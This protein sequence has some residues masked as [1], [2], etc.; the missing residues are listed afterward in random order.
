MSI[1][2]QFS[3][4]P[5]HDWSAFFAGGEEIL[6][7]LQSVC[8][9]YQIVS[10]IQL[11]TDVTDMQWLEKEEVWQITLQYLAENVGDLSD[12][13]RKQKM[14]EQGAKAVYV[15]KEVIRAKAVV[16][17]VGALV[18]PKGWP[19]SIPGFDRF[20]G[21]IF[22]SS[23]WNYDVDLAGKD[24]VVV[25]TGASAV[26]FLPHLTQQ[27]YNAKSVTQIM[28]SAP[29][30]SPKPIP[31]FGRQKWDTYSPR[32]FNRVP[33]LATM[34]YWLFFLEAERDFHQVFYNEP[35][36]V[37]ARRKI[38]AQLVSYMKENVPR[39]YHE[40]LIPDHEVGCKRR[41]FNEVWFTALNDP[42]IDLTSKLLT[43]VQP[44]SVTL[45][46]ERCHPRRKQQNGE[47]PNDRAP[48]D[49]EVLPADIII[50]ANGFETLKWVHPLRVRGAGGVSL[51]D[52]WQARAGPQAYMGT[53]VDGFPNFFMIFGPNTG[54][55][56]SSVAYVSE[57]M[58]NYA[59]KF[60]RLLL[61]GDASTVDVKKEAEIAYT[62]AIQE[63]LRNTV[64]TTGG[65][66][67]WYR[68]ED[69]WISNL[70][71]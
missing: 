32:I 40:I 66:S 71:P 58:T 42:K 9:K 19:D 57:N 1:L 52:V 31:P 22:H 29:W 65:A 16:S 5:K 44:K 63:R 15:R 64:W 26:Q 25:G 43:S 48:M 11:N 50:L 10:N 56:H 54:T 69:G 34:Y 37:E 39:K 38:E 24:V 70:Y 62:A 46:P 28:R 61:N 12:R 13:E 36:N 33:V 21:N 47:I 8:E 6:A 68:G 30:V 14:E 45:G 59:L 3:F 17:A 53:A 41:L 60:L 7:Y 49:E 2:Y 18:E 55:G 27:P 23:R 67:S 20:E 51:H 35:E 4:A